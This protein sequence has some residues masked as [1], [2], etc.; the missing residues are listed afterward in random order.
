MSEKRCSV[1]IFA[2]MRCAGADH[3]VN[4]YERTTTSH[5]K[6]SRQSRHKF[7]K[8]SM[9]ATPLHLE[10][11]H[12][13]LDFQK[14]AALFISRRLPRSSMKFNMSAASVG[15]A[16]GSGVPCLLLFAPPPSTKRY[17][18]NLVVR[19]LLKLS[20]AH[21]SFRLKPNAGFNQVTSARRR[22]TPGA[23]I[24]C[25]RPSRARAR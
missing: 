23:A 7:T 18:S 21:F 4:E 3:S 10:V 20:I 22:Q 16:G 12:T 5:P 19:T 11:S 1:G 14:S 9:P 8:M 17:Y 2:S 25:A 15:P 6:R 13:V 24:G